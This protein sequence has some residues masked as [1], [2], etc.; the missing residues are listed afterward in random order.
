M[1][2]RNRLSPLILLVVLLFGLSIAPSRSLAQADYGGYQHPLSEADLTQYAEIVAFDEAQRAAALDLH[3]ASMA[4]FKRIAGDAAR[5]Q[6]AIAEKHRNDWTRDAYREY[7]AVS[8]ETQSQ[9]ARIERSL[10]SEVQMLLSSEQLDR[11]PKAERKRRRERSGDFAN[12]SSERVDLT[13]LVKT[14]ELTPDELAKAAILLDQYEIE[15]DSAI[16]RRNS[17]REGFNTF[18][19]DMYDRYDHS[20]AAERFEPVRSAGLRV[21]DINR[22]YA[23]LIAAELP[24]E[25]AAKFMQAFKRECFPNVYWEA[26][27]HESMKAAAALENLDDS[28]KELLAALDETFKRELKS[29]NDALETATDRYES[30]T[31]IARMWNGEDDPALAAARKRRYDLEQTITSRL[32]R[33]LTP[34][35]FD[36]LPRNE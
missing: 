27:A 34:E 20:L 2:H 4:E 25:R 36:K 24:D 9:L 16:I 18:T 12:L 8:R 23:R 29:A 13:K 1:A 26:Q 31:P 17:L 22:R 33:I 15:L 3:A 35:Q 7:Y 14:A 11:W 21:R 30:T 5:R 6:R 19:Q 28:Q 32:S 10:L